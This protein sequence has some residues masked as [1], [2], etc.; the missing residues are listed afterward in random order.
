MDDPA[1]RPSLPPSTVTTGRASTI[2]AITAGLAALAW[3]LRGLVSAHAPE[4]IV[5]HHASLSVGMLS[6][7]VGVPATLVVLLT[8]LCL[9]RVLLHGVAWVCAGASSNLGRISVGVM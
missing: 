2:G 5:H 6:A 4:A 9:N 8:V 3:L 7:F 1:P